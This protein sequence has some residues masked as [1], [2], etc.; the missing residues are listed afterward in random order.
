MKN[1][2]GRK[3][4]EANID[5]KK[6][7]RG[8]DPDEVI[9]YISELSRTMQDASKLY[10]MRM[11]EMKQ[12]LALVNRERDNLRA[13]CE[14]LKKNVSASPP[15]PKAEPVIIQESADGSSKELIENLQKKLDE[16][17][18]AES[19][20][21]DGLKSAELH[22]S[23]LSSQLEEKENQLLRYQERISLLEEQVNKQDSAQ[24]QYEEA[25]ACIENLKSRISGLEEEKEHLIT[26]SQNAEAQYKKKFD[27]TGSLKT[28][29]SRI[30]V[31]NSL[32]TEK[33]EQ[34]KA[35]I[36]ELKS[37]AKNKAYE[38]A[39]KLSAEEDELNRE[40]TA[41]QKKLQ[42]QNYHIEQAKS[43]V[44]ELNR[45]IEQIRISFSE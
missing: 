14:E 6:V 34:Y 35:E 3:A 22:I 21:R 40:K 41:L 5:F 27:E 30:S 9:A 18:L 29:L 1:E 43:A 17:L 42:L 2:A 15:E 4:A 28:E 45:Q 24:E 38:Y 31:E 25:L 26:E 37:E 8:Y 10:E 23:E 36:S 12:E 44:D 20:F 19:A 39:E 7:M 32:L 33:N 16:E 11:A 13:Q